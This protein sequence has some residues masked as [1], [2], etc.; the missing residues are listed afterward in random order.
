MLKIKLFTELREENVFIS[1][2]VDEMH[3]EFK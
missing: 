1:C 3:P 2:I